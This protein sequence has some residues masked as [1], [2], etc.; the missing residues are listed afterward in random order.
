MISIDEENFEQ[1]KNL[2]NC[3]IDNQTDSFDS[4]FKAEFAKTKIQIHSQT[5]YY[6][7]NL[8]ESNENLLKT[9]NNPFNFKIKSLP[10]IKLKEPLCLMYEEVRYLSI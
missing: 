2:L 5:Q 6:K 9:P 10:S 4:A 8:N 1:K 7:L 3:A